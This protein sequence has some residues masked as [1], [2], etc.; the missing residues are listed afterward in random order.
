MSVELAATY[1]LKVVVAAS[2]RK[3]LPQASRFSLSVLSQIN[4]RGHVWACNCIS[5][6]VESVT[7]AALGAIC[8]SDKESDA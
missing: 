2:D 3:G 8:S 6:L 5:L 7:T 1:A 4:V